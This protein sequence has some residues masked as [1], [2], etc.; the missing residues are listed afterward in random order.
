LGDIVRQGAVH[1][2][3]RA[4]LGRVKP[5]IPPVGTAKPNRYDSA[6]LLKHNL[7]E[8][9][10]SVDDTNALM[11]LES[12]IAAFEAKHF[13]TA[14]RMLSPLASE[15]NVEAMY[16]MAIMAQNGLGMVE[17]KALAARYMTA[18]AESGHALAQHG[19][20]FMYME[21][22]GVDQDGSKALEWFTAAA[23]QGMQGSLT[24][25]GLMYQEGKGVPVDLD[26]ARRWYKKAGFDDLL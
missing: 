14:I 20:G 13:S 12:G 11:E 18:S 17:D 5:W 24:T 25:I 3:F 6:P 8:D 2:S 9:T 23:D 16:R 1:D 10:M 22:D 15:G 26:E 4:S 21:G 19:L 7:M